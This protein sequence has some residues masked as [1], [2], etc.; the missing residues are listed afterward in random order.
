MECLFNM[1]PNLHL[2][3]L[4]SFRFLWVFFQIED[5]CAQHSD[6][7]IRRVIGSLPR[8]LPATYH[9]ALERVVR[10]HRAEIARKMFRWVTAAKRP[11]SLM[12]I[13]EAIAVEPCQPSSQED[14]L[15]NDVYQLVPW[16]GNLLVLDEEESLVQFA[17]HSVKDYLLS[18]EDRE[19]SSHDFGIKRRDVDREAGEICCTY[20]NFSDFERQ[21]VHFPQRSS[22][23]DP[24]TIVETSLSASSSPAMTSS[25]LWLNNLRKGRRAT[26]ASTIWRQLQLTSL[27][28]TTM[29]PQNLQTRY[30]FL[31]YASEYWLHH[32]RNFNEE[33]RCWSLFRRLVLA[34]ETD[35][36]AKPWSTEEWKAFDAK[37]YNYVLETEHCALLSLAMLEQPIQVRADRVRVVRDRCSLLCSD[38][39]LEILVD[40]TRWVENFWSTWDCVLIIAA[41]KGH[42]DLVRRVLKLAQRDPG[43]SEY[44]P[45]V[46][47]AF[48]EHTWKSAGNTPRGSKDA[49]PPMDASLEQIWHSASLQAKCQGTHEM[50]GLLLTYKAIM[51]GKLMERGHEELHAAALAGDLEL[52][53]RL[54]DARVDPNVVPSTNPSFGSILTAAAFGG[55]FEVVE[56]LLHAGAQVNPWTLGQFE[57]PLGAAARQ[58][59]MLVVIALLAAGADVNADTGYHSLKPLAAAA[60]YEDVM[61]LLLL[62]GAHFEGLAGC[63]QLQDCLD[64]EYGESMKR[65]KWLAS[66]HCGMGKKLLVDY[67]YK[68]SSFPSRDKNFFDDMKSRVRS[69]CGTEMS[70]TEVKNAVA[71]F[72]I[73]R[74][75]G[76]LREVLKREFRRCSF[77]QVHAASE[78]NLYELSAMWFSEAI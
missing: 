57:T 56:L 35:L 37:F 77:D 19:I 49:P 9:R 76:E 61:V 26:E 64:Q 62:A 43:W 7:G 18:V 13:R 12:E 25:L 68:H 58:G 39:M 42:A 78:P 28:V 32:T 51:I 41:E 72:L 53:M 48:L 52:T 6:A 27:R 63:I 44:P 66:L 60:G 40:A 47:D 70:S 45:Q 31:A 71:A 74:M 8:D 69:S 4:T 33:N 46:K 5:I 75:N 50:L 22:G 17:H 59:H 34:E 1:S 21:L 3:R 73:W 15:V 29:W 2:G 10:N 36:A 14:K 54:L 38:E 16:C 23:L 11:L 67:Y 20:L 30:Y 55:S 65:V 24:N